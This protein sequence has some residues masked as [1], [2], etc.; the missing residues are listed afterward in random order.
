MAGVGFAL[1]RLAERGD[2]L[3]VVQAYAHSAT[4]STGPWLFTIL[5]L[6][7][8]TVESLP[9]VGS[10]GVT[11]FRAIVTYNF[12]FSLV[13]SGGPVRVI[14][15]CL[16][17]Q[18]YERRADQAPGML[19]GAL[20]VL[21]LAQVPIVVPFYLYVVD[22][23]PAVTIHA[24]I[25]YFLVTGLWLVGVFL[26]ALHVYI[27]V[28]L[29]FVFG[30]G[31]AF[32][33]ALL[34]GQWGGLEG[35]LIGF[36]AGLASILFLIVARTFAEYPYPSVRIFS[37]LR[38]FKPYW[39]LAL[40]GF[41]YNLAIWVDKWVMWLAPE[42]ERLPSGFV[43]NG[44]Y[45]T[46]MFLAYLS[47][48]PSMAVFLLHL[49]T[50]FYE[51]Y[52]RFY[53][54]IENHATFDRIEENHRTLIGEL[55]SGLRN[56]IVIQGTVSLLCIILA[57]RILEFLGVSFLQL[58][59][60]RFGV[61]GA[62]FHVLLLCLTIVLSYFELRKQVLWLTAFFLATNALFTLYSLQHGFPYYGYGYFASALLSF[63]IGALVTFRELGRIPYHTFITQPPAARA[64]PEA[65]EEQRHPHPERA[66]ATT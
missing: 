25:N 56:L 37:F 47:I 26:T 22:L 15:R 9:I 48:V 51:K 61:L 2:L 6:A 60:F 7:A 41:L 40:A 18:I 3:G 14:T 55:V 39:S 31:V 5:C 21:C 8:L 38:T 11:V 13:F 4:A 32:G 49:E 35:M 27:A 34:G 45:D 46:A 19:I 42:R 65:E 12:A 43:H 16:A 62:F 58:G 36:N 23:D 10:Q 29:S 63:L 64:T 50:R 17:D 59:I 54:E 44:T 66:P 1:R 52:L 30:L 20:L 28:S 57:P 24:I 33:L 53:R